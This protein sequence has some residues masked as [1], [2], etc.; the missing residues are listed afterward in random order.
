MVS[1]VATSA[2]GI[3]PSL[4]DFLT[5]KID[6]LD[7]ANRKS[8]WQKSLV[9]ALYQESENS[10]KSDISTP[11]VPDNRRETLVS[12][13]LDRLC[14]FGMKD[15]EERIA[16][17]YENT[18]RWIWEDR[19]PSE[20][21]WPNFI[22]W[23]ES[24]SQKLYWI[25]GKVGSGKS[26]LM[27]LICQDDEFGAPQQLSDVKSILQPKDTGEAQKYS[28]SSSQ[29]PRCKK[30]LSNWARE[31]NLITAS[32]FFWNSGVNLQKKQ[33]GLLRSLLYQILRQ[34]PEL[35]PSISPARWEALCLFNDNAR[36][37]TEQEL[38]RTLRFAVEKL[39][40]DSK[41]C[42]FVDGLDEFDGNHDDLI[43]LFKDMIANHNVKV[44]VSSRPWLVFED[45]FKHKPSLKLQDLSYQDIRHYVTANFDNNSGFALLCRGESEYADQL[46]NNIVDKASGVFLWVY[47]VV[48][49]LL[50]GMDSGDRVSDLQ[51]RLESLPSDLGLLYE[52]ILQSLDPFYLEHAAQL[53]KL[54]QES[55]AP[56]SILL[57]SFADE[58]DPQF[59]LNHPIRKLSDDEISFRAD[60]MRRRLNSRCKGFLEVGIEVENSGNPTVQYLHRTVK[61]YIESEEAQSK[62]RCAI[63]APFD[64]H[65]RLC[66][67]NLVLLKVDSNV[68]FLRHGTF[69]TLVDQCLYSASRIQPIHSASI[70]SILDEL[71]RTGISLAKQIPGHQVMSIFLWMDISLCSLF[72]AGNWV[73]SHPR[74][75]IKE[76][77]RPSFGDNFLSLAVHSDIVKFV[78]A[79][80]NQ[81]CLV[82]DS[83]DRV[84]PLLWDATGVSH[85]CQ[86][87]YLN[88]VPRLDMI[89]CLL[90]KGADPN[91]LIPGYGSF[92][93]WDKTLE[94]ILD[95]FDGKK[96]QPPWDA[97]A[98]VMIE[99]KAE[100]NKNKIRHLMAL[101]PNR[102][103]FDIRI[104]LQELSAMK[105]AAKKS[106]SQWRLWC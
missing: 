12:V 100:V 38:Q 26:T 24:D 32:F 16:K 103:T 104:I 28:A 97:I 91:F 71:D 89:T 33:E 15:R 29:Q 78:E 27:K 42:L 92:S 66:A 2:E 43:H 25:T 45:A 106:W 53:F 30:H 4:L 81:G 76:T 72:S 88:T 19:F 98:R 85:G 55:Y 69:W 10:P 54:V 74:L 20:K 9:A 49:S 3:G 102:E 84:W 58:E 52:K 57:L 41:I 77:L 7:R 14:Y 67:G 34:V 51:K 5:S 87:L 46:V 63:K 79:K 18:F 8:D 35:I 61:D 23:L 11:C 86:H 21:R 68:S 70:I 75:L 80:A 36:E 82:Q 90:R 64:P 1:Q 62:L 93:V 37:W 95:A 39:S 101:N 56:P 44:C 47:L 65:L 96:I 59:A 31:S 40:R 83:R 22:E 13:F 50:S 105:S 73:V 99:H 17:A 48:A 6:P 60:T 94:D